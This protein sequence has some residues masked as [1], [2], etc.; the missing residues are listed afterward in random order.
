MR[1]LRNLIG[2]PVICE[3][4]RIGTVVG[5]DL[6]DD[7][8][9]LEGIWMDCGLPGTRYIPSDLLV[10]I[11]SVAVMTD[12]RGQKKRMRIKRLL[13][14]AIS[15]DGRRI[16]AI[17]GAEIDE[18]S[19]L[20]TALE[21]ARGIWDDLIGGRDRITDYS[22][23]PGGTDVIVIDSAKIDDKEDDAP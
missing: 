3:K 17:T 6:S 23:A 8:K 13:Y 10:M 20:V 12:V 11:G 22:V 9:Q 14:R 4:Q 2:M 7:L 21:L 16:G 15:T 19:F 1:K 18:I 5:A